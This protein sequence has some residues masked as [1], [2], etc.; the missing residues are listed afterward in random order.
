MTAKGRP[1]IRVWDYNVCHSLRKLEPF[2]SYN[3]YGATWTA[4][5]E[6]IKI[7]SER[8]G[9]RSCGCPLDRGV[10]AIRVLAFTGHEKREEP[11]TH[12]YLHYDN[13]WVDG[14]VQTTQLNGNFGTM[15]F[16]RNAR[17]YDAFF[18]TAQSQLEFKPGQQVEFGDEPIAILFPITFTKDVNIH[19]Q[20]DLIRAQREERRRAAQSVRRAAGR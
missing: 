4:T 6:V 19:S 8:V 20:H 13:C 10:R 18:D 14:F 3:S 15:R 12:V 17:V 7:Q 16:C 9:C 1:L 2:T 11:K 5:P